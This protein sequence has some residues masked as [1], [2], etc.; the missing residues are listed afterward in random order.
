FSRETAVEID[1]HASPDAVWSLLTDAAGWPKWNSTVVSLEGEI[2]LGKKV[3]LVSKLDPKRTFELG[4]REFLPPERLVWGDAMGKRTYTV[5]ARGP[6][7]VTFAMNEKIG[8]PLFPLFAKMIPDF[9]A[10]FDQFAH[11]LKKQAESSPGGRS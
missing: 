8:G 7:Q 1:I 6:G 9:D 3:K 11:D 5:T 2:A 10:S 4:V